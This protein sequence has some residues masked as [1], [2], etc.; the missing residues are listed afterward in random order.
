MHISP[1]TAA[2]VLLLIV[3]CIATFGRLW[4]ATAA[5][6]VAAL[7]LNFFFMPPIGTFIIQDPQNWAA[8]FVFVI[9]AVIGSHLSATAQS[10]ARE[11]ERGALASTLL[12]SLAHDLR[13][14][15]TAIR[16]AVGNVL[17]IAPGSD[18]R[19]QA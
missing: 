13:T 2:L 12:A 4:M 1:T 5:A 9:V 18:R 15:L 11:A 6:V 16:V 8:L 19:E 14:P 10:R 17:A 7:V 3:L